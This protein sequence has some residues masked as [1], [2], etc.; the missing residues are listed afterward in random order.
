MYD[1]N[2]DRRGLSEVKLLALEPW[3]LYPRGDALHVDFLRPPPDIRPRISRTTPIA[4]IGSC[5]AREIK[6]W[7]QENGYSFIQTADGP[8]TGAGSA[9][10]DR[11]YNTFTIRQEFE[12]AF[13]TFDPVD[14]EWRFED[15]GLRILDPYRKNIAWDDDDEKQR[16]LEEH[17]QNVRTAFG[18]CEVLIVTVGQSEIWYD[19]RDG[20]VFPLVPPVQ[21]Y[22]ENIHGFRMST[23]EENVE[24][25]QLV[26]DLFT[27]NNPNGHIL[28]TTSPVPLRATFRQMNAVVA[29]SAGKAMLRAAVDRVCTDN[30]TSVTYFP[31]YEIVTRLFPEPYEQDNRHVRREA[32]RAIME[33]FEAWFTSGDT[34]E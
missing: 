4:S 26:V 13:G 24:N 9:R 21:I 17:Q 16:E 19:R 1:Y 14:D 23:F 25:L 18:T 6:V 8:G 28:L 10:Y 20:S 29:D 11:V 30:P 33:V 15:D 2:P 3:R 7:L 22:D 31:S 5:F 12:R 34:R 32:V 27:A